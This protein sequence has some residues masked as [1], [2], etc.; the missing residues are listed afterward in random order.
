MNSDCA[1]YLQ[2]R[3]DEDENVAAMASGRDIARDAGAGA[4]LVSD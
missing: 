1:D 3:D 2:E 4:D